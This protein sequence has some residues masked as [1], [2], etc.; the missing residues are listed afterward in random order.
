MTIEI[1]KKRLT[2]TDICMRCGN[3]RDA[4]CEWVRKGFIPAAQCSHG[5][6]T[7]RHIVDT[8]LIPPDRAV[9]SA[10]TDC[11][12]LSLVESVTILL[13]VNAR[14][15]RMAFQG[16]SDAGHICKR[17]MFNPETVKR[18]LLELANQTNNTGGQAGAK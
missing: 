18:L 3:N 14:P 5:H 12:E 8:L 16:R 10:A 4:A 9:C 17:R 6:R 2:T 7:Q 15:V 11:G 13:D 1:T